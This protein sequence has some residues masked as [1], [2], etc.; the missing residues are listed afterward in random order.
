MMILWLLV[1]LKFVQGRLKLIQMDDKNRYRY[2]QQ[3]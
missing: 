1:S 3:L 2:K